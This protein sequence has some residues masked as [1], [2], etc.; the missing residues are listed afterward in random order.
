LFCTLV[1]D[2]MSDKPNDPRVDQ[3]AN[4]LVENY[5]AE[6]SVF[7]PKIWA[8]KTANVNKMIQACLQ[9]D[10]LAFLYCFTP[11]YPRVTSIHAA[12]V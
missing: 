2:F 6:N 11:F 5:I 12:H 10:S 1:D 9:Y 4:Y 3:F 7:P 8:A